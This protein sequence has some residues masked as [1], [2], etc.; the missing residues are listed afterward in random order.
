[1]SGP[2]RDPEPREAAP[3]PAGT[4]GFICPSCGDREPQR[5]AYGYPSPDMWDSVQLGEIVL[6]G[7]MISSESPNWL[8]RNCGLRW[9]D[10]SGPTFDGVAA[11][12][13]G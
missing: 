10:G 7:C 11:L 13:M 9:A 4:S 1:M 8:C 6:G 2:D 5:I 12:W 3:D